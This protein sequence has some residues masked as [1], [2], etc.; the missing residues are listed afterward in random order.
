LKNRTRVIINIDW[1]YKLPDNNQMENIKASYLVL[2]FLG[3]LLI[4]TVGYHYIESWSWIDSVFMT[5]ITITTVGY[6]EVGGELS[7][8]GKIFT[9]LLIFAGFGVAAFS[10]SHFASLLMR[11]ELNFFLGRIRMKRE[12]MNL[13][14]HYIIAGYGR[15]GKVIA[16]TFK[17]KKIPYVVVDNNPKELH[18]TADET[19]PYIVGDAADEDILKQAGINKAK[20]FISVMS[21]D[22]SNAFAIMTA[23][24]L[25]QNLHIIS[26][27]LDT[28]SIRK[29]KI[30]G[31]NKV[32][33]P[34]DLGGKRIAHSISHPHASDFIEIVEDVESQHIEMAD[35]KITEN[36]QLAGKKIGDAIFKNL[37]LIVIGIKSHNGDFVFNPKADDL[38]KPKHHLILMGP[39]QSINQLES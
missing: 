12:I 7:N 14:E 10:L 18:A 30:A 27:A 19:F 4:G 15:T 23:R 21:S 28:Q 35:L 3:T 33:A 11:G 8:V 31:A 20:G 17:I 22:A 25:N 26:R 29:L 39:S 5:V 2:A 34:Y 16:K 36:S 6:K 38:I 37:D 32:I 13:S 24:V 1:L 9:M